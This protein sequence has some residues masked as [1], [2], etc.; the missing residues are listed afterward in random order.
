LVRD[1]VSETKARRAVCWSLLE[2]LDGC[3]PR[4]YRDPQHMDA[5]LKRDLNQ[6]SGS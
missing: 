2:T 5:L 1:G 4:H 3:L 6:A